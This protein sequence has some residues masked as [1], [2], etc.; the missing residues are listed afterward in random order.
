MILYMMRR[1]VSRICGALFRASL[2]LEMKEF[3]EYVGALMKSAPRSEEPLNAVVI[4]TEGWQRP[5]RTTKDLAQLLQDLSVAVSRPQVSHR[6]Q[7]GNDEIF[8]VG[9][10][11]K[12]FGDVVGDEQLKIN[13]VSSSPVPGVVPGGKPG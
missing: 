12:F 13:E 11:K 10:V 8:D 2:G 4:S 6:A 9:D 3:Q 5:L 1:V 7:A